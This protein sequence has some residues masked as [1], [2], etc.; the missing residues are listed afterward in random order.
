MLVSFCL[1]FN[2]VILDW[3]LEG[4]YLKIYN[5]SIVKIFVF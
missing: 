1:G 4:K 3:Y 5:N 2:N